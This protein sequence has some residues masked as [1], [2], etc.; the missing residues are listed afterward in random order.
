MSGS[1]DPQEAGSL[2]AAAAAVKF[3][4]AWYAGAGA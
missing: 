2:A 3:P 1:Y 4:D